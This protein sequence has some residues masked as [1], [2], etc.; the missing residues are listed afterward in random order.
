MIEILN[1]GLVDYRQALK[2]QEELVAAVAKGEAPDT[3]VF[4][5]HPPVVTIGRVTPKEDYSGWTGDAVDVSRGGRATFHGPNQVIVYPII[6]LNRTRR[7]LPARDLH[8]YLR[9]LGGGIVEALAAFGIQSEYKQGEDSAAPGATAPGLKRHL[10][11]VWVGRRKIAS[12]GVAARQWVTYHGLALNVEPSAESAAGIRPCGF[13]PELMTSMTEAA[14]R[15][16]SHL[17]VRERLA[18]IFCRDLEVK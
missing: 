13:S 7:K 6:S 3:L 18:E 8:A 4:C 10:T 16:F 1:W 11:G 15:A 2:Q 9:T 14:G 12:I 17:A 5:S